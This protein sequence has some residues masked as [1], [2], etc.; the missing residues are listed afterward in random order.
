MNAD[1]GTVTSNVFARWGWKCVPFVTLWWTLFWP[2]GLVWLV[3]SLI[4]HYRKAD[5]SRA[6]RAERRARQLLSYYPPRWR[7][8]YGEEFV[9]TVR[10]AIL[11]GHGGLRLELNVARESTVAW[12]ETDRRAFATLSCW[13][14][15]WLPLVAQSLAP[16]GIKLSGGS[17]RGW[18]LAL[19]VPG[20]FQWLVVGIMFS[21]G[22]VMLAAAVRGLPTLRATGA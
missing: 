4:A 13:C 1:L 16:L 18:F 21:V 20:G 22:V 12:W 9:E 10:Q 2:I 14:L 3:L 19:F 8:R 15:C 5:R 6:A 17:Y 7:M 11:D